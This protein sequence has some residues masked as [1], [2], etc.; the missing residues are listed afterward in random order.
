MTTTWKISRNWL[1]Q[2]PSQR[3][4]ATGKNTEKVA[5]EANVKKLR[6]CYQCYVLVVCRRAARFEILFYSLDRELC[7]IKGQQ[8]IAMHVIYLR[9]SFRDLV[10]EWFQ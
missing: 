7:A 3:I 10:C 1:F 8:S 4:S 9:P 2:A 6:L 5:Y